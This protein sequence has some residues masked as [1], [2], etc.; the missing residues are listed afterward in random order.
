MRPWLCG[1]KEM[2]SQVIPERL[3][4]PSGA[5]RVKGVQRAPVKGGRRQGKSG[6]HQ[7]VRKRLGG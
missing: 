2:S 1:Q 4:T 7:S 5:E 6:R 3:E